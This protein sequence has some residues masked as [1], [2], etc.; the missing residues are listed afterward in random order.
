MLLLIDA[1]YPTTRNNSHFTREFQGRA[2][3]HTSMD[4]ELPRKH[5]F[6]LYILML[7]QIFQHLNSLEK[8]HCF[9]FGMIEIIYILFV[10]VPIINENMIMKNITFYSISINYKK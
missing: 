9:H 10:V 6:P 7:S 5:L 1:Y 8:F 3:G 2:L 4:S